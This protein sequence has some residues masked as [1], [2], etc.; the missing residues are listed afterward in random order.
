VSDGIEARYIKD[1]HIKVCLE[2]EVESRRT[3]G[4]E[5]IFLEPGVPDFSLSDMD[6][7]CF[8][9]GRT[10]SLPLF[11]SSMTGGG[12]QSDRINLT[13]AEAA[14]ACGIGL[15]LGSLYP[16]LEKK[17]PPESYMVRRVAP[18]IPLLSNLGLMHVRRGRD[19]LLEAIE[20]IDA[21][22]IFIYVNPLHEILQKDGEKNFRGCLE[23]LGNIVED[24]PYPVFLK[25]VGFGLGRSTMEWASTHRISGVDVAGIGGTNWARVEGY[26]QQR[27]YSSFEDLG[28]CTSDAVV[29]GH[30]IL[31]EDRYLIAS[32]GIRP[33]GDMAKC[34]ALGAHLVSMAL[35]F[36]RWAAGSRDDVIR[37]IERL[38]DEL[39]VSLWYGGCRTPLD[40][41]GRFLCSP[42]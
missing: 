3:T 30:E 10:L 7:T 16:M 36:L 32:G 31:P 34:F 11:V 1:L 5:R 2:Q 9:L 28:I 24:F 21:D 12:S 25:E 38:S 40:S 37:G 23:I 26:V 39:M 41:R 35:P 42:V 14:E 15:S 4:L 22:G 20:S 27:D 19:Y 29:T 6:L 33:G 8:F 18:S 17:V 13:L